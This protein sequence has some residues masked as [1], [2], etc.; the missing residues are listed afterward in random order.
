LPRLF[1]SRLLETFFRRW[2]LYVL[3][4]VPFLALGVVT[5]GSSRTTY[6][7]TGVYSVNKYTL[8]NSALGNKTENPFGNDTA[9]VYT[10]RQINTLLGTNDFLKTVISNADGVQANIDSGALT[11][12]QVRG[13]IG[14]AAD[15]DLLVAINAVSPN[16]TL[17]QNLAAAIMPSYVQWLT[18]P[19]KA[20]DSPNASSDQTDPNLIAAAAQ[21][22]AINRGVIN[23]SIRTVDRPEAPL[24]PEPHR[25]KDAV[26]LVLFLLLGLMVMAAVVVVATLLDH[27]VRYSDEIEMQLHVPVLAIVPDSRTAIQPM[28][29]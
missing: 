6:R 21:D 23:G 7:S 27:S 26:T 14:V 20:Q 8:E 3:V 16:P 10:S 5:I 13:S 9:A 29:L 25:K 17:S 1:F 22:A 18:D 28:V 12:Q 24:G 4:L 11:E 19:A 2:W 15:G